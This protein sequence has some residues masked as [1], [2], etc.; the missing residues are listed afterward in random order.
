[1]TLF[2][3]DYADERGFT[4]KFFLSCNCG[5]LIILLSR[6]LLPLFKNPRASAKSAAKKKRGPTACA[7]GPRLVNQ[8]SPIPISFWRSLLSGAG[9][10]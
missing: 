3:A 2:A 7:M 4:K 9:R 5:R 1:M 10:F 8:P 6:L